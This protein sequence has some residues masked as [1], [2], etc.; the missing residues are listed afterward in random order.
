M[1]K[2]METALM[3]E[4]QHY[5]FQV[6]AVIVQ[7]IRDT[8]DNFLVQYDKHCSEKNYC[9]IYF[10]SNDIY[11][12]NNE[13]IFRKRIVEQDAY[14][15]YGT[16]IKKVYKHIFLRDVYKQWYLKGINTNIDTPEKLSQW[17]KTETEGYK[18]I[19]LGSSAGGYAAMLYG[20]LLHAERILAF[21]PQFELNSLFNRSN[22]TRNPILYRL[23]G[24][25]WSKYFDITQWVK[26]RPHNIFYFYSAKSSWDIKQCQHTT[27]VK[28]IH[29]IAFSTSHHGIPFLKVALPKVI[30][31]EKRE[32]LS[33]ES[34]TNNPIIFTIRMVGMKSAVTGFYKQ[35]VAAKLRRI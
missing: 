30:N 4:G 17:L 24:S 14:E 13:E 25:E 33:L 35:I 5:S 11:Y 18:V 23:K 8:R 16:R 34:Q 31:M 9:A 28:G 22:E 29:R 12:P 15:W 2:S 10:S 20:S 19:T 27:S 7:E 1:A 3:Y 32:L 6:D 26:N 21:N